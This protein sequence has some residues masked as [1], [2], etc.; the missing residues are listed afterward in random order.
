MIS[1]EEHTYWLQVEA[2]M[3]R[4]ERM[5]ADTNGLWNQQYQW[6]RKVAEPPPK[7]DLA[8]ERET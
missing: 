8:K 5:G 7:F 1:V 3:Y 6:V 4:G 2:I